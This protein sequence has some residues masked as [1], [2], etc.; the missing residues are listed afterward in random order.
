MLEEFLNY[1]QLRL[2]FYKKLK[3]IINIFKHERVAYERT[4]CWIEM[5]KRRR[6]KEP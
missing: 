6:S 2:K 5:T 1:V 4:F 3:A